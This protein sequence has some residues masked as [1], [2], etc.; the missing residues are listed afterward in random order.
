[1]TNADESAAKIEEERI[2]SLSEGGWASCVD[3]APLL[4]W[5]LYQ[6]LAFS[7]TFE[8]HANV[9]LPHAHGTARLWCSYPNTREWIT[10]R[11]L[12]LRVAEWW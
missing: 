10:L 12:P 7:R 5:C 2:G 3:R 6:T 1:M 4:E 11:A 8:I 9:R